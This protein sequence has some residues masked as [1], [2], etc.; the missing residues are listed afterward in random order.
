LSIALTWLQIWTLLT[1]SAG[2]PAT[3]P[4]PSPSGRALDQFRRGHQA[5][6]SGEYDQAA[7]LLDGLPARLPHTRD[8]VLYV[9]AESEFYAGRAARARKLFEQLAALPRSPLKLAAAYRVADCRWT[10]GD[11]AGAATAYRKLLGPNAE[12]AGA[13]RSRNEKTTAPLVAPPGTPPP[14]PVVARFRIAM[15]LAEQSIKG[16][17]PDRALRERALRAFRAVHVEFPAHPL[18]DRAAQEAGTLAPPAANSEQAA[19]AP[20]LEATPEERIARAETLASE[21]RFDSAVAELEKLSGDLPAPVAAERDYLLGMTIY[22]MRNDYARSAKLLLGAV[23][24][25]SGDKAASAAFHGTR[26]LSRVHRD[27]DAIAGY[28]QVAQRFSSSRYAP[29]AQFLAGWLE[30]NRGRFRESIPGLEETLRQFPRTA[31]AEDAAWFS[32]LAHVLLGDGASAL[33][34]LE[35]FERMAGRGSSGAESLRRVQ[36]FRARALTLLGRKD[37]ARAQLQQLSGKQPFSYYGL[38][39]A[40]R[41][42]E[43]GENPA[44]SLPEWSGRL[45]VPEKVKDATVVRVDELAAAG[46]DVEAGLEL[47]REE[48]GVLS[49]LG[50]ERGLALLFDRYPRLSHWRRANQLAEIHGGVALASAPSGAAR[51]FW[52]AAYPR[53]FPDLVERFGPPAGNPDLFLYAIMLKESRF[54]PTDVS[55][56]DARGLLQMLPATSVR[57]A[58]EMETPFSDEQLFIPEVNVRLGARYIGGLAR[59]F[60]NNIALAAGSYNAGAPAMM[61]WCDRNGTRPLDEFIELITYEQTREYMKRVLQIFA[62]YQYLYRS[63]PLQ[64]TL[65]LD[66]CKYDPGGPNY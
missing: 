38:V 30:L 1:A 63:Q 58:A 54:L 31:F 13:S 55:Y 8:Y 50:R 7:K 66:G 6:R 65:K 15:A 61:R 60:R 56:A 43:L 18:A 28:R 11:H 59:K 5:F 23:D 20:A 2:I 53:A 17:K 34:A 62:R 35:R 42:R 24:R 9:A 37:E 49:R 45:E 4:G 51:T 46:M 16:K 19:A 57:V 27:D 10:E 12:G 32:A 47:A 26:A 3:P 64:I 29:E 14:D 33:T 48:P 40:T 52:E 22:K 25:L 21:R 39:A 41:L 44:F 36:Y